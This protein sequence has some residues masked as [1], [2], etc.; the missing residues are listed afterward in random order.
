MLETMSEEIFVLMPP[1]QLGG[2]DALPGRRFATPGQIRDGVEM[3]T[4]AVW[5]APGAAALAPLVA[6]LARLTRSRRWSRQQA[7]LVLQP[8][9]AEQRG[10]L[11]ELFRHV[12]APAEHTRVLP[13]AELA[14]VLAAPERADYVVGATV[15]HESELVLLHRGNLDTVLVPFAW[16]RQPDGG[17]APDFRDPGVGDFGQTVRFGEYEAAASAILY[18]FDPDYRKRAKKRALGLDRSLAGSIRRMRISRGLR[19]SD[20][21]GI[22]AK[23]IGRIERGLVD[24][25]HPA[26]LAAIAERFGVSLEE[27]RSH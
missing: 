19:Q 4:G 2:A 23:E 3:G 22:S 15:D 17:T 18:D 6:V 21:P 11:G 24:R 26:T 9:S 16:F 20:F 1:R 25:P 13:Q 12:L 8:L 5:V 10:I 14:E 27:L 7:L